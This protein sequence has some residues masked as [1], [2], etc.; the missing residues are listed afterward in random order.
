MSAGPFSLV[1]IPSRTEAAQRLAHEFRDAGFCV[2]L[3]DAPLSSEER[4]RERA[5]AGR[6]IM[7]WTP[8]DKRDADLEATAIAA[9][10]FGTL[11]NV[12]VAG[13]AAPQSLVTVDIEPWVQGNAS[14]RATLEAGLEFW[15]EEP[16]SAAP[17]AEPPIVED[18]IDKDALEKDFFKAIQADG[19]ELRDV[20]SAVVEWSEWEGRPPA[21]AQIYVDSLLERAP[22]PQDV[23]SAAVAGPLS[24]LH[25]LSAT[26]ALARGEH[27]RANTA[28][29]AA[30]S[31][32]RAAFGDADGR[33][34]PV[35]EIAA[36]CATAAGL[37]AL[38]YVEEAEAIRSGEL[39]PDLG[40]RGGKSANAEL[41]EIKVHFAT[42]RALEQGADPRLVESYGHE[43]S[44]TLTFGEIEVTVEREPHLVEAADDLGKL[45]QISFDLG[46]GVGGAIE[47]GEVAP[48]SGMEEWLERVAA[49]AAGEAP[50]ALLYIHGFA[51]S[52]EAGLMGAARL[53]SRLAMQDKAVVHYAWPSEGKKDRYGRDRS[54]LSDPTLMLGLYDV[55][56]RVTKTLSGGVLNIVAHSLGNQFLLDAL[57]VATKAASRH[58]V[59]HIVFASPDLPAGA[60]ENVD[61]LIAPMAKSLTVYASNRDR[62]LK[63]LSKKIN[64]TE[65]AGASVLPKRP[66]VEFDTID[67]TESPAGFWG[68]SDYVEAAIN[69]LRGLLWHDQTASQRPWIEPV[70]NHSRAFKLLKGK[71]YGAQL[72]LHLVASLS[73]R[74]VGLKTAR[75]NVEKRLKDL[76]M[77]KDQPD[78]MRLLVVKEQLSRM[79]R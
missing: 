14:L 47:L 28:A 62:A 71:M 58:S 69:D 22:K 9:A 41:I 35:L 1:V 31:T 75:E 68:H 73:A 49:R 79:S 2:A 54:Q 32:A 29:L 3:Q 66:D 64:Q 10:K 27:A 40:K 37:N 23:V 46:E 5:L 55:I 19:D 74:A 33:L 8:G 4:V 70:S 43:I 25:R 72:Q 39:T 67:T 45:L 16:S 52:F 60:L 34:T 17:A 44:P 30:L 77:V 36:Q 7:V 53:G 20:V 6:V 38:A 48:I 56:D 50:E 18:G 15:V 11:L 13:G 51:Q 12:G 24:R 42:N 61:Q 59:R 63:W 21:Q 26:L 57:A 65:R 78:V 76:S